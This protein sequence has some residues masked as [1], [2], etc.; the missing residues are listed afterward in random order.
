MVGYMLRMTGHEAEPIDQ[1]HYRLMSQALD[2]GLSYRQI[3]NEFNRKKIRLLVVLQ[4]WTASSVKRRW[5][6]LNTLGEIRRPK[7]FA[8]AEESKESTCKRSA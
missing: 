2:R 5:T 6:N 7:I 1:F 3:A 4:T 8:V